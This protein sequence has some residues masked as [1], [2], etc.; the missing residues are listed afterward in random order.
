MGQKLTGGGI[1][2]GT[3]LQS[4]N[5]EKSNNYRIGENGWAGV[6][7]SVNLV[8]NRR[9]VSNVGISFGSH[10]SDHD[11]EYAQEF[12]DEYGYG[13][14]ETAIDGDNFLAFIEG[15]LIQT[16]IPFDKPNSKNQLLLAGF[17]FGI[18][19]GVR[20]NRRVQ[21]ENVHVM[22]YRKVGFMSGGLYLQPNL[23]VC[24]GE[25]LKVSLSYRYFLDRSGIQNV[26]LFQVGVL[27]LQKE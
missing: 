5:A 19:S 21:M 13:Y 11:T 4:F 14:H 27:I 1:F 24:F 6:G 18:S 2:I 12:A 20:I 10:I 23:Y 25:V 15:G 9:F 26:I 8:F 7:L 3:G 16:I 17:T 22:N